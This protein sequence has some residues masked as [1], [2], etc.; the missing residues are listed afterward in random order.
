M[1]QKVQLHFTPLRKTLV[2]TGTYFVSDPSLF[3]AIICYVNG[4]YTS[5]KI[6]TFQNLI[7]K[8]MVTKPLFF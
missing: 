1:E 3:I 8:K 6:L 2:P 5:Y 4:I 7:Q